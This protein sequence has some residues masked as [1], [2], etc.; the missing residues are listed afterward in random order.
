MGHYSDCLSCCFSG[1]WNQSC[2]IRAG[3]DHWQFIWAHMSVWWSFDV[4]GPKTPPEDMIILSFSDQAS[5]EEA[6]NSDKSVQRS[7][8]LTFFLPPI[9]FPCTS[10]HRAS[11]SH[12][13]PESLALEEAH[14]GFALSSWMTA[15]RIKSFLCCILRVWAFGLLDVEQTNLVQ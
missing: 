11:L 1:T 9:T 5:S 12:K 15:S 4:K 10:K 6:C 2:P 13:N 14:L 7:Y 3:W 8:Y